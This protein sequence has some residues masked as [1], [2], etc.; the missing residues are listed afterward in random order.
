MKLIDKVVPTTAINVS[1]TIGVS[2]PLYDIIFYFQTV[3]DILAAS[4]SHVGFNV[5]YVDKFE[6]KTYTMFS[7]I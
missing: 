4:F 2:R 7:Q 5:V 3:L 1:V 6:R